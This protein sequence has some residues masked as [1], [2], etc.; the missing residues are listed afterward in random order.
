MPDAVFKDAA[1]DRLAEQG[2]V[3]QFV[4][5]GPRLEQRFLRITG[6][7][8]NRTFASLDEAVAAL[9]RQSGESSVNIRSYHPA[10]PKSREF[11]YG[12]TT[13]D[14]A[15]SAV[16]RLAS[17]G[18]FTIVN[19]TID[20]HDGGVSGVV[21]G[22]AIE[23]APDSTPRC[24]E[25]P[26]TAAVPRRIG[27]RI[28]GTVY[29][30]EPSLEY[31]DNLRVEF[32]IH[33]R[34]R[35]VRAGHTLVWE[36]EHLTHKPLAPEVTWPNA[37]SRLLGDK[38]YGLLVAD[39]HGV[40]VP[41]ATVVSRRVAPF[42]FGR[43]TATAEVWLR[44]S[45]AEQTPGFFS[46]AFGWRDPFALL[47]REDPDSK[48]ASVMAQQAVSSGYSGAFAEAAGE[49]DGLLVEG[50]SG[51]G[52]EFMLGQRA[53]ESLPAYVLEEVRR[54]AAS[55]RDAIGPVRGEW[56]FDG[57]RCWIVQLHRARTT[58]DRHEIY[59]GRPAR[60]QT[61]PVERGLEALRVL[62]DEVKGKD[63]GIA[64]LG[65]VGVTSHFGDVLRQA[66]VPSY[67]SGS[68]DRS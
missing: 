32:S 37:F 65:R 66:E 18:L 6:E 38:V 42:A 34:R 4:S 19:E 9:L 54:C 8:A 47:A 2:N 13:V 51:A 21:A 33:P 14:D 58:F 57:R 27:L 17:H 31:P 48:V 30:F 10:S 45:P 35:G 56:V 60:Y 53:P 29:G 15:V 12:L 22:D 26:G 43:E 55:V 16:R 28:L 63:E 7:P 24:V 67:L 5:F 40:D 62:I 46:T 59:P 23:F 44:T 39:A 64:L 11:V 49:P 61:F 3:A 25:E 36:I 1:L 41:R 68:A 52:D 20:V 50:V